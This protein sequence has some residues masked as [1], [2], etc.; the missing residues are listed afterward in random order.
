MDKWRT[1]VRFPVVVEIFLFTVT[2]YTADD[3]QVSYPVW[4]SPPPPDYSDLVLKLTTHINTIAGFKNAW[5]YAPTPSYI[6]MVLYLIKIYP[7]K[8]A[9]CIAT[10]QIVSKG[11]T[12]RSSQCTTHWDAEWIMRQCN[13]LQASGVQK[14]LIVPCVTLTDNTLFQNVITLPKI[15]G[16]WL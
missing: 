7:T 12:W 4:T 8:C 3:N 1:G 5:R 9:L 15:W 16:N 13:V 14:H 10:L 2:S 6:V 11:R